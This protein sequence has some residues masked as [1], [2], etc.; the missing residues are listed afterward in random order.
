ML[1]KAVD[2]PGVSSLAMAD[3][4]TA[5]LALGPKETIGGDAYRLGFTVLL[6]RMSCQHRRT[7]EVH[8]IAANVA[9]KSS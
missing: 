1:S 8:E 7:L 6:S 9:C 2:T 4:H 5:E 3:R